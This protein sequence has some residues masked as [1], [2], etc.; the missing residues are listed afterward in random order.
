MPNEIPPLLVAGPLRM[1]YFLLPDGKTHLRIPGGPAL[2]AAAGA[3]VWSHD[4]VGLVSRVGKNFTPDLL[5]RIQAQ[6]IDTSG[7][8]IFP[9]HAPSLGFNYFETW[10]K[11]IDWDPVKFF[12]KFGLPCP[13]DLLGYVPPTLAENTAQ[14]FPMTAVH[15]EDLSPSNLQSRAAYI[16]PCHFQSQVTL[17]VALRRHGIGTLVLSPPAGLL[18]PSF[19]PQLREL[20]HGI[21]ILFVREDSLRTFVDRSDADAGILSEYISRWGPKI[22]LLQRDLQGIHLYDSDSRLSRFI[23]FY[24]AEMM[25]PVS[26]GNAFCGGFLATWRTTFD[27]VES[28]LTGCISASLAM[29]GIGGLFALERNPGLSKARLDSL[30]RS[31]RP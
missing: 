28:T 5:H 24:P 25:N 18:L 30:R 10:E 15:C 2:Y 27:P 16:T 29:E 17:S 12:A 21:D 11:H 1:E 20:L 9:G 23:P 6:G 4:P 31:C 26:I 22:I 13:D 3:K 14:P 7:I 19:R 8:R